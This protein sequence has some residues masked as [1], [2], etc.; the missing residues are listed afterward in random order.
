MDSS[1]HHL[2]CFCSK[3]IFHVKAVN[4]NIFELARE[5]MLLTTSE[6]WRLRW[7]CAVSPDPSLF[8]RTIKGTRRGFKES[9][10]WPHCMA[11]H[12][13]LKD[14]KPHNAKVPFLMRRLIIIWTISW[15]TNKMACAPSDDLD[16]PGHPPSLIR[17]FA[18]RM[19]KVWVLSYP[20][21]AQR[22]LWS[23]WADAH[24][25][26]SL[27]WAHSRFV[28]FVMWRLILTAAGNGLKL[29]DIKTSGRCHPTTSQAMPA[30]WTSLDICLW[31]TS[32]C[33]FRQLKSHSLFL[34][35][36]FLRVYFPFR[37]VVS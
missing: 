11:A 20:F 36:Y 12:A 7:A 16:Q 34:R 18:V 25:D 10:I 32:H 13:R 33:L 14:L 29:N 31:V 27:R 1:F 21:S 2:N 15:Q 5:K 37:N 6:Q 19:K 24:A 35:F 8:P 30:I 22:R 28:G 17:V 26:L 23:D 9:E 4:E 3:F